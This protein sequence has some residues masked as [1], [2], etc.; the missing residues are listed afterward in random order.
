[1][2]GLLLLRNGKVRYCT[3]LTV[4]L[5]LA[6]SP[7]PTGVRTD[8]TKPNTFGAHVWIALKGEPLAALICA[9]NVVV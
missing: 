3:H 5:L 1:M 4:D 7:L 9:P 6:S 2:R 8:Q